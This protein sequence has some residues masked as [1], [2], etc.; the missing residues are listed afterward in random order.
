MVLYAFFIPYTK[1]IGLLSLI[2]REFY[3]TFHLLNISHL[4]TDLHLH[5]IMR[6]KIHHATFRTNRNKFSLQAKI[7]MHE[8]A[9]VQ[10]TKPCFKC[11]SIPLGQGLGLDSKDIRNF[12]LSHSE[13]PL[14]SSKI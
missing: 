5:F 14:T 3:A 1:G 11:K 12:N 6:L 10:T 7:R 13:Y 4:I 8:L 9:G 2:N